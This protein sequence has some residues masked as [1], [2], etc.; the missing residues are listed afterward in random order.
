MRALVHRPG[1]D[2]TRPGVDG[3]F[4]WCEKTATKRATENGLGLP[5]KRLA[6]QTCVSDR[7]D[8]LRFERVIATGQTQS[9]N[10]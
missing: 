7:S 6:V 9:Q 4:K 8:H 3:S 1:F 5:F 10:G 2:Q